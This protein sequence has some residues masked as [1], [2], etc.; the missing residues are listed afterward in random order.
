M[1]SLIEVKNYRSLR[2]ISRPLENFH[3]LIGA[4]ATGKTTFLDVFKLMSDVVNI[5]LE[6]AVFDRASFFEELTFGL[7]GGDIELA[8]EIDLPEAIQKKYTSYNY[9]IVRYELSLG[10][11]ETSKEMAIK[12][13]CVI[14]LTKE[15]KKQN[16]EPQHR[17]DFP[18]FQDS[19]LTILNSKYKNHHF[20][21]VV[22]KSESGVARYYFETRE[23]AGKGWLPSF[24]LGL[25]RSA[26][27][28]LPEDENK[29][30]AATWL[31]SFLQ[32]GVQLF[33]LNSKL[34]S[35]SCAPG[36]GFNFKTDGS[37]L[38]LVIA[39]LKSR[40]IKFQSWIE[41]LQTVLTDITDIQI[42]QRSE[43]RH[44]YIQVLYKNEIQVPG[45]LLSDGTLRLFAL[46]LP[47]YLHD[48]DGVLLI[49]EPENGIHPKAL[50]CVYQSLS[51]VYSAQVLL[52]SHSPVVLSMIAQ[53]QLLCFGKTE[54]G[55]SDIVSG[56][57]HPGLREWKGNPNLNVIFASG[58]LS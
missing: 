25:K 20:K 1:I 40:P 14:L 6:K 51:S 21:K 44:S 4:N 3:V 50:E 2:F 34:M 9:S 5:G 37:N 47:A 30:P 31:K 19:P 54:E 29:F 52:A 22:S 27:A 32:R 23:K 13:E 17:M 28:N 39:Q 35:K 42:V 48:I 49:E 7:R 12:Y 26:L 36:Q 55:V 56:I 41:H 8:I 38:P 24:K 57:D 11:T 43:D 33:V 58:I 18:E 46:T 16:Q 45:H 15:A 53:N 10:L